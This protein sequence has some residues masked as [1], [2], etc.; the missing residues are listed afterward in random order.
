MLFA[1]PAKYLT[2]LRT[3]LLGGA[4]IAVGHS[5]DDRSPAAVG[6]FRLAYAGW[7]F[8]EAAHGDCHELRGA[9]LD[10]L[11]DATRTGAVEPRLTA[12]AARALA[13]R[14]A[15]QRTIPEVAFAQVC[16]AEGPLEEERFAFRYGL[17][18]REIERIRE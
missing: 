16:G 7:C 15:L 13:G 9:A 18:L 5:P 1:T 4:P 10:A 6:L 14:G 11:H 8:S 17:A 3:Q 12:L 2:G